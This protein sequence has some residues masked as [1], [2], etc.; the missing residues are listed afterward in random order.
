MRVALS[1]EEQII[2]VLAHLPHR[3]GEHFIVRQQA[4]FNAIRRVLQP[5]YD[6]NA[7]LVASL[8]EMIEYPG[9]EYVLD[10]AVTLLASVKGEQE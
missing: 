4:E 1:F 6:E 9:D 8:D 2:N 5:L 7:K 3:R 10:R